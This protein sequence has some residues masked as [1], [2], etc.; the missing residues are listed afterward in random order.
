MEGMDGTAK[1]GA[2]ENDHQLCGWVRGAD[3]HTYRRGPELEM[4]L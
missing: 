3:G 2:R 4:P 1:D